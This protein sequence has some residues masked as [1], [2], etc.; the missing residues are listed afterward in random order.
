MP[1]PYQSAPY[2]RGDPHDSRNS[3]AGRVYVW[4]TVPIDEQDSGA[5]DE[6]YYYEW[7]SGCR[8]RTEHDGGCLECD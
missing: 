7:C 1:R 5:N 4:E 6:G 2:T 3:R 8:R